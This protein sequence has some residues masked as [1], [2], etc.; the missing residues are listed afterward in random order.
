MLER[1]TAARLVAA[2]AVAVSFAALP[3]DHVET[4]SVDADAAA[5]IADVFLFPSPQDARKLVGAITFGGAP[6]PRARIDGSFYCDPDVLYTYF[7]DRADAAGS[8]DSIPDFEIRVRFGVGG[9]GRCG[10][11]LEDVPGAGGTFS[12]PI[13][14]VLSTTSGIRAFAGLR[15]DPFFFD[16]Q[17]L[18]AL[19]NTFS[20]VGQSGDVISAFRVASGEPRRDS[21][22][23]RNV[24]AI[25]FEMDLDTLAPKGAD[26]MRPKIR[27]WAT[28]SRFAG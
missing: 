15:N 19:I 23:F 8:F 25:V 27:A 26:G 17:G 22:G 12:G 20:R 9:S 21:F 3:A 18:T 2:A 16:P 11:Q 1:K 14:K 6:Q 13:E 24:S 28:T 7:I 4:P 5:D 10:M